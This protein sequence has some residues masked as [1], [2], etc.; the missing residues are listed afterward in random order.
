[1]GVEGDSELGD[2][3]SSSG[4]GVEGD[5]ELGDPESSS[6]PCSESQYSI[7]K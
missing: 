5:S 6:G 3:E 7:L 4:P 2:P 1:M